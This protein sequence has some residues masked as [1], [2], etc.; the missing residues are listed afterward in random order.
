[1]LAAAAVHP[2]L[3]LFAVVLVL[4]VV[5]VAW[6]VSVLLWPLAPCRHCGGRGKNIGSTGKRWGKCRRCKGTGTRQ[7][8]GSRL[9]LRA[10]SRKRD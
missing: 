3:S 9:A 6:V 4:I 1:M 7:R 5:A 2:H 10:L 8:L